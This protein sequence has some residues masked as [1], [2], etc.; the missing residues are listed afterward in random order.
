LTK[1]LSE[2]CVLWS[3]NCNEC[4]SHI[5]PIL[6]D[7]A[8]VYIKTVTVCDF[9][10]I[11]MSPVISSVWALYSRAVWQIFHYKQQSVG[12]KKIRRHTC[13]LFCKVCCGLLYTY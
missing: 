9:R 4:Q 3:G 11:L 2:R 10:G 5:F 12:F 7:N 8:N 6:K 1:F 13:D